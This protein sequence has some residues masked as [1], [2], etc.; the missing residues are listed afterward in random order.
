V[1][2]QKMEIGRPSSA[3]TATAFLTFLEKTH[4]TGGVQQLLHRHHHH[5]HH[6]HRQHNHCHVLRRSSMDNASL[7][8]NNTNSLCYSGSSMAVSVVNPSSRSFL[9]TLTPKQRGVSRCLFG[10]PDASSGQFAKQKVAEMKEQDKLKWG[11]DFDNEV[12]LKTKSQKW[13]WTKVPSL[14]RGNSRSEG[15][16]ESSEDTE[17]EID[18]EPEEGETKSFLHSSSESVGIPKSG[19]HCY[20][21]VN[22]ATSNISSSGS[23]SACVVV[24]VNSQEEYVIRGEQ[25]SSSE[26]AS[27]SS[28][29][30]PTPT[31]KMKLQQKQSSILE[32]MRPTKK[33]AAPLSPTAEPS[34]TAEKK[35]AL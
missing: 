7:E 30:P 24:N 29:P 10:P 1:C 17:T 21:D 19:D 18:T 15:S 4:G 5:R 3:S 9:A 20:E 25:S 23:R 6:H 2:I 16:E 33:R 11:F 22:A 35:A 32:Y 34:V 26:S 14:H 31:K 13:I 12:P 8:N 28:S 27:S